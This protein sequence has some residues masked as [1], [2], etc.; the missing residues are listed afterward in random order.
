MKKSV[1]FSMLCVAGFS[2][3][4]AQVEPSSPFLDLPNSF[5]KLGQKINVMKAERNAPAKAPQIRPALAAGYDR[6]DGTLKPGSSEEWRPYEPAFVGGVTIEPL[7]HFKNLTMNASEA[8]TY[9]WSI[10]GESLESDPN[11]NNDLFL[12]MPMGQLKTPILTVTDGTSKSTYQ[13]A[14]KI[15]LITGVRPIDQIMLAGYGEI[16]P[17]TNADIHYGNNYVGWAENNIF[18]SGDLGMEGVPVYSEKDGFSILTEEPFRSDGIVTY[19]EKPVSPLVISCVTIPVISESFKPLSDEATLKLEIRKLD[20]NGR[21]DMTGEPLISS[22]TNSSQVIQ[23]IPVETPEAFILKF[24]FTEL[25]E[26]GIPVDVDYVLDQAC[27]VVVT[28]FSQEGCDLSVCCSDAVTVRAGSTWFIRE[29]GTLACYAA[30][31]DIAK[32]RHDAS[33]QLNGIYPCLIQ[34]ITDFFNIPAEGGQ[35]SGL[36]PGDGKYYRPQFASTFPGTGDDAVEIVSEIPSWLSIVP[37]ESYWETNR[38]LMYDIEGEPLPEGVEERYAEI[39]FRSHGVESKITVAQRTPDAISKVDASQYKV[40]RNGENFQL[41]YPAGATS[42]IV[43]NAL[44]QNIA[45]YD[46]PANGSM[47]VSATA[48]SN[49]LNIFKFSGVANIAVKAMK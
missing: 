44:G 17:L 21:V 32:P 23:S 29:D 48:L 34:V 6:P 5:G 42:V 46:L 25:N 49:G 14:T 11:N 28:G 26:F 37:D 39:V 40:V 43:V 8:A 22:T 38:N 27:A 4:F 18:G 35:A 13:Y 2:M 24:S 30:G 7:W 31:E 15:S 16:L 33:V 9:A 41:S 12:D 47:T 10:G 20:E 1:L 36:Y 19:F 45:Q 3:T